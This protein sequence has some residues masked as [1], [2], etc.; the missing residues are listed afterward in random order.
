MT[1]EESQELTFG[2][3]S[4]GFFSC[5]S[6]ILIYLFEYINK[7]HKLP[8]K[9]D[10]KNMLTIYQLHENHDVFKHCFYEKDITIDFKDKITFSKTNH[11]AQ[12]S[13][14]KQLRFDLLLPFIEK[15]YNPTEPIQSKIIKLKEK[16]NINNEKQYCGVFYRGNDKI[17]ETQQPSYYEVTNKA[18]ELKKNN[19]DII[20]IIQTDEYEFLKH[21]LTIFPDSIYFTEIPVINKQM[22]TIANIYQNNNN[23]LEILEY[24]IASIMIFSTLK[25]VICT[26]GNGELF[27]CFFRKNA[28][29]I[30]QYL[31]KNQY[32]HGCYNQEYDQNE[33]NVWF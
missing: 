14:Y 30:I 16:Y 8:L 33:L 20:F 17:K 15:Y 31:K 26:Y 22:T 28:N 7:Y 32:I 10:T 9:I 18:L 3:C 29:G 19:H 21:F 27:M 4:S 24:Y 23:K 2:K 6:L 1:N 5:S 11:E 12:F 13:D 25:H